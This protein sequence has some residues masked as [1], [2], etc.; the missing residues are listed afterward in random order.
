MKRRY[1]LLLL[2]TFALVALIGSLG[3]LTWQKMK[4]YVV[5]STADPWKNF[6]RQL[7]L[8]TKRRPSIIMLGDSITEQAPW[9]EITGCPSLVNYGIGGDT[10][11]GVLAR[12]D[13]VIRAK[14][15]AVFLMV[16]ANDVRFRTP[17]SESAANIETIAKRLMGAGIKVIIHPVLP[18]DGA[19]ASVAHLNRDVAERLAQADIAIVALPIEATDLR[20]GLHLRASAYAKW[21]DT[22]GSAG[23][24]VLPLLII[25]L[26]RSFAGNHTRKASSD[27]IAGSD[28]ARVYFA[29]LIGLMPDMIPGDLLQQSHDGLA[30]NAPALCRLIRVG[31]DRVASSSILSGFA[32]ET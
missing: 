2:G 28:L 23:S 26:L 1:L 19:E 21:R 14:S 31:G 18:I 4:P 6:R 10:S 27:H 8:L 7:F 12:I 17:V 29:Q 16:G 11:E 32:I 20:D 24:S 5:S 3:L 13:D 30:H 15:D 22:I 9:A 25:S